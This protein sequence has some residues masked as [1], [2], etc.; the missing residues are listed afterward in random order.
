LAFVFGNFFTCGSG[1]PSSNN[2]KYV[3]RVRDTGTGFENG[4][5]GMIYKKYKTDG[6]AHGITL[7]KETA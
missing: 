6:P 1:A 5:P 7:G 4:L 2:K 3:L